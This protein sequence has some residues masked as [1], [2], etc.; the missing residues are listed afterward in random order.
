MEPSVG[1]RVSIRYRLPAGAAK[2]LTDV[3]GHLE[4]LVPEVLVRTKSGDV[5]AIDPADVMSTAFA[6]VVVSSLIVMV[7]TGVPPPVL[8]AVVVSTV[9][10]SSS[11]LGGMVM[12]NESLVPP[13]ALV[14]LLYKTSATA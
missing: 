8:N 7:V 13:L 11:P 4:A 5:V 14:T 1:S 9:S 2:P 6:N 10:V 12:V 3:V